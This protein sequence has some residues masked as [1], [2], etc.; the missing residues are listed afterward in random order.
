MKLTTTHLIDMIAEI[1]QN[2]PYRYV[3]TKSQS[4]VELTEVN[5]A[6]GSISI[7]RTTKDDTVKLSKVN[8][9]KIKAISDGLIENAPISIDDLLRNNDNVRS[10]IEAVLVRTAEIYTYTVR[11][12]KNLVWVPSHPHDVGEIVKLS[13]DLYSLLREQTVKSFD[14]KLLK[15]ATKLM[16]KQLEETRDLI[17]AQHDLKDRIDILP[18]AVNAEKLAKILNEQLSKI[19]DLIERQDTLHKLLT[20]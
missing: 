4:I 13:P 20:K 2:V 7:K 10:A 15:T 6:D 18:S 3:N 5:T 17:K 1:P 11:N 9:D 14:D 8:F 16:K 19:S 12:H